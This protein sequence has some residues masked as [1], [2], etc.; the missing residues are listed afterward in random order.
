LRLDILTPRSSDLFDALPA[1][2]SRIADIVAEVQTKNAAPRLVTVHLEVQRSRRGTL[3]WR[4]LDYYMLL[5]RTLKTPVLSYAVLLYPTRPAQGYKTYQEK[6]GSRVA[7]AL[8]YYQVSLPALNPADFATNV[9][10]LARAL[11]GM[12]KKPDDEQARR[13]LYRQAITGVIA[14]VRTGNLR[15]DTGMALWALIHK[16]LPYQVEV[17]VDWTEEDREMVQQ[18]NQQ[19]IHDIEMRSEARGEA[20]GLLRA[21]RSWLIQDITRRFGP[22]SA[23]LIE[24]IEAADDEAALDRAK[25]SLDTAVALSDITI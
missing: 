8:T 10:P 2:Y 7:I 6:Y 3:G 21:K 1:W 15:K 17:A 4:M 16:D 22:V 20:R 18:L 12:M 25:E 5:R 11:S 14:G 19:W 24:R 13:A 23:S 9:M